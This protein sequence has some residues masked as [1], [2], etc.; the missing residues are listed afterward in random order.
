[1]APLLLELF[2]KIHPELIDI[3]PPATLDFLPDLE[4]ALMPFPARLEILRRK[5]P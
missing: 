2:S 1:L 5:T 4:V 3:L